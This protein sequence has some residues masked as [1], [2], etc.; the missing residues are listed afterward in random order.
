MNDGDT[1]CERFQLIR[2]SVEEKRNVEMSVA[3]MISAIGIGKHRQSELLNSIGYSSS[4]ISISAN[5]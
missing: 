5:R 1:I 2:S 3:N 4:L